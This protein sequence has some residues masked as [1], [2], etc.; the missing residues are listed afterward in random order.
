[1]EDNL[2]IQKPKEIITDLFEGQEILGGTLESKVEKPL[3]WQRKEGEQWIDIQIDKSY[4]IKFNDIGKIIRAFD[5]ENEVSKETGII[6]AGI[7]GSISNSIIKSKAFKFTAVSIPGDTQWN[8]TLNKTS[9]I[10]KNKKGVE[11]TFNWS[12]IKM[13]VKDDNENEITLS[14]G[15]IARFQLIPSLPSSFQSSSKIE[16][17]QVRDFIALVITGFL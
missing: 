5:Q 2:I 8:F 11:K 14:I 3:L 16:K 6:K 12:E 7:I 17:N 9:L 1:M 15:K 10:M 13:I 4:Y